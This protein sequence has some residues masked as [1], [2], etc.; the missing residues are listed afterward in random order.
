MKD[1]TIY[2]TT[3]CGF[4]ARAKDLLRNLGVMYD[5]LDVTGDDEARERLVRMTGGKRTVP[6]IW[7]GKKYVGGYQ[8]LKRMADSGELQQLLGLADHAAAAP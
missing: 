7:V 8:D 5:E 2:S 4:C 1:V 3:Y 6:Q